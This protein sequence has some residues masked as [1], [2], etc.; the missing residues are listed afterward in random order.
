MRPPSTQL[1][2]KLAFLFFYHLFLQLQSHSCLPDSVVLAL[3]LYRVTSIHRLYILE[4]AAVSHFVVLSGPG[5]IP[6]TLAHRPPA[7]CYR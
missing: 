5:G 6:H 3:S 1:F 7:V 4:W 2:N